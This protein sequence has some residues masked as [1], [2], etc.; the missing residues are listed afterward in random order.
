MITLSLKTTLDWS[1]TS[2]EVLVR[3][4]L[5]AVSHSLQPSCH[6]WSAFPWPKIFPCHELLKISDSLSESASVVTPGHTKCCWWSIY[7]KC[8]I[9]RFSCCMR[10]TSCLC[11]AHLTE[12]FLGWVSHLR[13]YC[14]ATLTGEKKKG[15]LEWYLDG[16]SYLSRHCGCSVK[17]VGVR[18]W[19]R[20]SAKLYEILSVL[21]P[22][23]LAQEKCVDN[24]RRLKTICVYAIRRP[25]T[26]FHIKIILKRL[27]VTITTDTR[28]Y[29]T[30]AINEPEW[31]RSFWW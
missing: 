12:H 17:S 24:A 9:C 14:S 27:F 23:P 31:I 4:V 6:A 20:S 25:N 30:A 18:W 11:S 1:R 8:I 29:W 3:P 7:L 5:N 16:I 2:G 21:C 10:Y 26:I 13:S 19:V 22:W 15:V 28:T